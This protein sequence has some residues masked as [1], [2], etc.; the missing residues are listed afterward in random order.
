MNTSRITLCIPT[1]NRY[2]LLEA[3]L[4]SARNGS[5]KP[6]IFVIDNGGMLPRHLKNYINELLTPTN[7]LG[8]GCSW[9]W[10]IDVAKHPMIICNDDIMFGKDDI[11]LFYE[12]YFST[13]ADLYYTDN[14]T[15]SLNMFSCFMPTPGLVEKVGKFDEEFYPAY[16]EDNDY[17]YRMRLND[18]STFAIKTELSHFGSATIKSYSD[19]RMIQHHQEFVKNREYYIKKWGGEPGNER[20]KSAFNE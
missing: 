2:D 8:V 9:N 20:Y 16:F 3:C 17:W 7:N 13:K 18:C 1:L 19:A 11:K 14:L 5:L 12:I 15:S 4:K 6:E 10:F